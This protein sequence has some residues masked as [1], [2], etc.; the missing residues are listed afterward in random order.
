[1]SEIITGELDSSGC[2]GKTGTGSKVGTQ[3]CRIVESRVTIAYAHID[4][5]PCHCRDDLCRLRARPGALDK[6]GDTGQLRRRC[7]CP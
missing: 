1:M 6:C 7:R 5:G 4:G 2:M 3:L